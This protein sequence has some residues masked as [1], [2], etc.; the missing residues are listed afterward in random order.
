MQLSNRLH[1]NATKVPILA[2]NTIIQYISIGLEPNNII[3]QRILII[4]IKRET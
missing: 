2:H 4:M 1:L 3:V